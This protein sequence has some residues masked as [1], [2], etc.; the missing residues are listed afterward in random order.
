MTRF[1]SVVFRQSTKSMSTAPLVPSN[2][3]N[4]NKSPSLRYLLMVKV[5]FDFSTRIVQRMGC[6]HLA[7]VAKLSPPAMVLS[8]ASSAMFELLPAKVL[9]RACDA[10]GGRSGFIDP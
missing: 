10:Y 2:S 6:C 1:L 8:T 7:G 5:S 9:G 4:T 3:S